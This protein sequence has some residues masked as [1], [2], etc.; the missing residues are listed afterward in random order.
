MMIPNLIGVIALSG[1]VFAITKNYIDRKKKNKDIT[2]MLSVF[3]EIQEE[4]EK[5]I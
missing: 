5:E 3:P 4:A 1:T 2:P